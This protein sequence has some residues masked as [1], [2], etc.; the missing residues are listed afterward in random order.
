MKSTYNLLEPPVLSLMAKNGGKLCITEVTER[1]KPA[2]NKYYIFYVPQRER[3]KYFF[4]FN[5]KNVFIEATLLFCSDTACRVQS[6]IRPK[7]I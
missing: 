2:D 4:Q 6:V 7:K 5:K 3:T 1:K